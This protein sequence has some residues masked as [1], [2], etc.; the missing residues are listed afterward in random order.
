MPYKYCTKQKSDGYRCEKPFYTKSIRTNRMYCDDCQRNK[1]RNV[2]AVTLRN[3]D[4]IDELDEIRNVKMP[5]IVDSIKEIK[6]SINDLKTRFDL[7]EIRV[8]QQNSKI[9]EV[10]LVADEKKSFYSLNKKVVR[11]QKRLEKLE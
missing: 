11:L 7:I 10:S 5:E 6:E 8:N 1:S 3:Q 9:D 4:R 2:H